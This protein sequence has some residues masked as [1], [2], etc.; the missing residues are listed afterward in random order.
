VPGRRV[1]VK[2]G[3]NQRERRFPKGT[4]P[5]DIRAW[6][7]DAIDDLEKLRPAKIDRGT[8]DADIVGYLKTLADRPRLQA[9]RSLQLAWWSDQRDDRG[10]RY[11]SRRRHTLT[12]QELRAP[13]SVLLS[14]KSASTTRHYRT[15]L[16]HLYTTLDGKDAPNPLRDIPPPTPPDPEPRNIPY[17]IIRAILDAMPDR[18]QG[19][20]H[21]KRA[22]VSKTK[23]RLNLWADTG[24]PKAQIEQL[25]PEH[26]NWQ[27]PSVLV[28][29]RKKG[30]GTKTKRL[31]LTTRGVASI[32]AFFEGKATGT[33]S[34]SSARMSWWR[35]IHRVVDDL[36]ATDFR[37]AKE[38]LD[39]LT[40]MKARPYDLRHSY[41]T[42]SYLA[43]KDIRATQALAMHSDARMTERYTLAAVDPRLLDVAKQLDKFFASSDV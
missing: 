37:A 33:F 42:A 8:F 15:A 38:L 27:D 10:R 18:G 43:G 32:A 25:Q 39:V 28:Q 21:Q 23:L 5:K 26:V 14:T 6:K 7:K 24:L 30:K 31:P 36:A 22:T 41:L 3:S 16:F 9:D 40:R 19:L 1:T 4:D 29:G 2:R 34:A 12:R 17:P 11:G 20:R 13:L 35:A